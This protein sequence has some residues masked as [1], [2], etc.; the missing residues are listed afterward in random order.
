MFRAL[1]YIRQD[2]G[3]IVD[4]AG[5]IR[6]E[7]VLGGLNARPGTIPEFSFLVFGADEEVEGVFDF[8]GA[9]LYL[10][11]LGEGKMWPVKETDLPITATASGSLK[12][13]MNGSV[14]WLLQRSERLDD[15]TRKVIEVRVLVVLVEHRAGPVL[16]ISRNQESD[17]VFG[18][19]SS[20]VGSAMVVFESGDARGHCDKVLRP[21]SWL[22]W[23][24]M[25]TYSLL[26]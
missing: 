14:T 23:A 19:L 7:D 18:Q 12:P 11:L 5:L 8:G 15:L 16:G 10:K 24:I 1:Y 2:R 9:F 13:K 6:I 17:A 22:W 25:R 21:V 4:V 26:A 20:E 3:N